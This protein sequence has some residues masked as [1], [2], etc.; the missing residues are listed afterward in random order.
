MKKMY[1]YVLQGGEKCAWTN[2]KISEISRKW[3]SY[4][5]QFQRYKDQ[6]NLYLRWM[7]PPMVVHPEKIDF[8][9]FV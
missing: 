4:E 9:L 1:I 3:A 8:R 5:I 2:S 6:S 7:I